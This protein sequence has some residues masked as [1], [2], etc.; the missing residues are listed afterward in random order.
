[1][2]ISLITDTWDNVNGVVTTLR[3]TVQELETRGHVVQVIHPGLFKTFPMPGYPEIAISWNIWRVGPLLEEFEPD[4]IHIATEGPLGL[5]ARWYCK[6]RKRS[7]PHNSSYHTKYPE[8]LK[9]HYKIPTSIGYWFLRL[10]HKFSH[11]V[12]VTTPTMA[13]ELQAKGFKNLVVWSRGVDKSKFNPLGRKHN[14]ASKPV[15][16][17]VSRASPE[18]GLEDFCALKT[19]GTK[20]LVGDGPFLEYLKKTYPDVIYVGYKQGASLQHAYANADVFVFPSKSD[21]FGVVML[22]SIACGTP[23]AAYPVTGPIDVLTP[24]I[25]GFLD[26]DLSSAIEKCLELDRDAV[27]ESSQQYTWSACTD[28]FEHNLIRIAR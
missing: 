14:L 13:A 6:V 11:R 5:A 19:T 10:F 12:L 3:A 16:L 22:E 23:V 8:Y 27:Y 24:G 7:I 4:A 15:L 9:I 20:L 1:M 26:A 25:N 28:I 18:K 21:T 2:K 17:C